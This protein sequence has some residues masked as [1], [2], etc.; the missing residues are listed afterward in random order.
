M[1][2]VNTRLAIS[3][4]EN[5]REPNRR[6]KILKNEVHQIVLDRRELRFLLLNAGIGHFIP[7]QLFSYSSINIAVKLPEHCVEIK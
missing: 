7:S 5:F 4:D 3:C 6:S 1:K 2:P